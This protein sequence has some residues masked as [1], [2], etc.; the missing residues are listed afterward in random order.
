[1]TARNL[2]LLGLLVAPLAAQLLEPPALPTAARSIELEPGTD[3]KLKFHFLAIGKQIY[4]CDNGA[5]AK[6]ATPDAALYDIGSHLKVH[7]GAGPTWTM[8]DGQGAVKAIGSTAIHFASPDGVSIDWL[9]LD[10]DQ[11]SRTGVF[12]DIGI[13]QRLYTGAGK[14]PATGCTAD[15]VYESAY[16][17]HYYFWVSK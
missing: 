12:S 7:H 6:A 14:A 13:I 10:V 16:T 15:Q 5:W 9:K 4:Q 17:A 1:M 11:A 3:V 2:C 8:V